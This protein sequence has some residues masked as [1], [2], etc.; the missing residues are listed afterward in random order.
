M[1]HQW[2][3]FNFIKLQEYFLCAK[4]TKITNSI[5][6]FFSSM[7][8]FDAHSWKYHDACVCISLLAK[9]DTKEKKLLIEFVVFVFFTHKKYSCSFIKLRLNHWCHM[10]YFNDVLTT[11]LG[12]S[13]IAVF[14]WT[15]PLT[16][17]GRFGKK[18]KKSWFFQ[19]V[20]LIFLIFF[21]DF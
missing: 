1:W 21:Y 3:R 17:A 2:F 9:T 18:K 8:V 11:F 12:G 7:S 19:N 16:R 5:N 6:N 15:N 13:C 20:W 4:K 10:D 14:G